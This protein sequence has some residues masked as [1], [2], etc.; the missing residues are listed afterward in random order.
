MS[1]KTCLL[2]A[3]L[4]PGSP[5]VLAAEQS[6]PAHAVFAE[7]CLQLATAM[8]LQGDAQKR[9]VDECVRSKESVN[10]KSAPTGPF[11]AQPAC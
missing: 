1:V 10:N 4:V 2:I 11:E 6:T 7:S 9:F 5:T 8:S 3:G